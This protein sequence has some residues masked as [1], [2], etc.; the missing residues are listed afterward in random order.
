MS[1]LTQTDFYKTGHYKQYPEG[2]ELV[3]SNLT[4]RS[5]R[6][7]NWKDFDGKIVFFG[8]QAFIKEYLINEWNNNFFK[9]DKAEVVAKYKRRM[10]TSLGPN[11]VSMTHIEEL[12]DL[13]YLPIEIRALPEGRKVPIGVPVLT[14]HNTLD[15]FYWLTNF[16]ETVMSAELWKPSTV[17][18]IAHQYKK[19]LVQYAEETGGDVGFTAL[20]GHDFS[21]RG[22][23][24]RHDAAM[25]G[26]GH[27][28]SFVGTDTIPAI[29][30]A[31]EFYSADAEK[32]LLG[33]SVPATEHSV[34]CSNIAY[35]EKEL[36]EKGEWNGWK[37]EDLI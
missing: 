22:M 16:L 4:P 30:A 6:L 26:M 15:K 36:R 24:G 25:S 7:F 10:D 32:E 8:L 18:T 14:I 27:L 1:V 19:M 11:A 2:T 33:T 28:I 35:I 37:L 5:S 34:A 29:D 21:F 12:Y 13:G 9:K 17:A 20:Q 23:S 3:Y 31:E